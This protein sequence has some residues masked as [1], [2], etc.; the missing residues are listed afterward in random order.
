MVVGTRFDQPH[1]WLRYHALRAHMVAVDDVDWRSQDQIIGHPRLDQGHVNCTIYLAL[2]SI[3][4][5]IFEDDI[6]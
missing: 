3:P 5:Q 2:I 6:L 1:S 4:I